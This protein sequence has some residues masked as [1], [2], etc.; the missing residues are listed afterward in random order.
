VGLKAGGEHD[1]IQLVVDAVGGSQSGLGDLGDRLVDEVSV[2][3][4]DPPVV[5]ARDHL[6]LAE[7]LVVRG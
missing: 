1:R 6:P 3:L 2:R 4:T 7:R 5:V